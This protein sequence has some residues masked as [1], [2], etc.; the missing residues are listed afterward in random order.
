[1]RCSVFSLTFE[2]AL[3]SMLPLVF[4][5]EEGTV[6]LV[7]LHSIWFPAEIHHTICYV[8]LLNV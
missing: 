1:M 5:T 3:F 8:A 6:I 4:Q 2:G 7:L